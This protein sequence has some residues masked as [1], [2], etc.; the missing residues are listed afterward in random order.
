VCLKLREDQ[1][2]SLAITVCLCGAND[3]GFCLFKQD[4]A[5]RVVGPRVVLTAH[6]MMSVTRHNEDQPELRPLH[7]EKCSFTLKRGWY[8]FVK[9]LH[10]K[11]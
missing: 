6:R 3:S 4:V 11:F 1:D 7:F 10:I 2:L 9:V 5:A 8:S